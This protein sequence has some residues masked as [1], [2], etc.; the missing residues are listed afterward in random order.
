MQ[1][2]SNGGQ[3]AHSAEGTTPTNSN[4]EPLPA[5][6]AG[7]DRQ[8]ARSQECEGDTQRCHQDRAPRVVSAC[9]NDPDLTQRDNRG[10]DWRP[11]TDE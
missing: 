2:A 7:V 11:Q 9:E 6:K 4:I 8:S 10:G 5:K 1:T 3:A